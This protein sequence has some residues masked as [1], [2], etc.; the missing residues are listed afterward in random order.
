M[1]KFNSCL[2]LSVLALAFA[3]S[4]HEA[5]AQPD[6]GGPAGGGYAN[7]GGGMGYGG[8]GAGIRALMGDPTQRAEMQVDSLRDSLAVT[9]DAEWDVISP[10]LLKVVQLKSDDSMAE[11]SR[12]MS[13]MMA[14]MGAGAGGMGNNMRGLAGM[15][16][17]AGVLGVQSDPA[18]DALQQ[19]LDGQ[20][21][22]AQV[23][24]ALAK[25]RAAKQQKQAELAKAQDALKA[26]LSIRQEAALTLAGYLE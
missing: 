8:G 15:G 26:V 21:S 1:K 7:G 23:K 18:A 17:I 9:N 5:A 14:W 16:G 12:M 25:F 6:M 22:V 19:V 11:I 20:G 13:P 3:L 2:T 24:A 10:R 4:G